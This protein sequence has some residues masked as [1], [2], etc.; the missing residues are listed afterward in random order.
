[1][2]AEAEP[3][4]FLDPIETPRG[5][6]PVRSSPAVGHLTEGSAE[7]V[8][9]GMALPPEAAT[10][11]DPSRAQTPVSV[12]SS[13]SFDTVSIGLVPGSTPPS[14]T[15]EF[16]R[17]ASAESPGDSADSLGPVIAGAGVTPAVSTPDSFAAI[18][19]RGAASRID[20]KRTVG[21]KTEEADDDEDELP[22][23]GPSWP[24]VLLASYASAV[25]IGLIW[26]LLGRR[27]VREAEES[28]SPSPATAVAKADPGRRAANSRKT[29]P[30]PRLAAD[31]LTVLGE[32]INL[33]EV[34]VTPIEIKSGPVHLTRTF[35]PAKE[36]DGGDGA[37]KLRLRLRNLSEDSIFAPLDEAFVR[38][39]EP[40]VFDSFIERGGGQVI[41]MY[42]LSVYSEWGIDGQEF[43]ELKPGETLETEVVSAAGAIDRK[44][45]VMTWRIRLRTG[46][47]ETDVVGVTFHDSEIKP[48]PKASRARVTPRRQPR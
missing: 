20:R 38:E 13:G 11:E 21:G 48:G 14:W 41:D 36:R 24:L 22:P 17:P 44:A 43:R 39:R 5:S 9:A 12:P 35:R 15:V 8:P 26:V 28:S 42:P 29:T 30:P 45:P 19:L 34:E 33:G 47:N 16:G 3:D 32:A 6:A 2:L 18:D 4:P 25:T 37:L 27:A 10:P 1:M 40:G 46:I 31:H 23:H 7:Q